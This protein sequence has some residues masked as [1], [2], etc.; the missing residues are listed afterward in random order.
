MEAA[1][2]KPRRVRLQRE[3]RMRHFLREAVG[4]FAEVGFGGD[5]KALA[6]RLNVGQP[7]L[8]RYFPSKE[9]LIEA[10]FEETFLANWNPGWEQM[11]TDPSV[12]V[13]A[14][15]AAFHADFARVHLQRE[16]IRLSMFFALH[17]WNMGRYFSLMRDHV[18][19]PI[20]SGLREYAGA[21]GIAEEPLRAPEVEYAKSVVEKIQY[22]G[23]RKW[24][25]VHGMPDL[26]PIEPLID[27]ALSGLL[28]GARV[29]V[30]RFLGT[31]SLYR[32]GQ[33]VP[34]RAHAKGPANPAGD[35]DAA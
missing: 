8:Y 6:R 17:G 2:A 1:P 32:Y 9:A 26:P 19:V 4:F 25:Y 12:D 27:V 20:A 11:L 28:A 18:Y 30:P 10:V 13:P 33:L 35:R 34:H 3:D 16:R 7:L 15:L 14:R 31:G 23:I 29:A 24:V 22:Y 5:T 21:P